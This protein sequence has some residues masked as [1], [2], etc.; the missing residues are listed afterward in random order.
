MDKF[1]KHKC[2]FEVRTLDFVIIVFFFLIW[3]L[4]QLGTSFLLI[5]TGKAAGDTCGGN[6]DF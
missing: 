6:L 1:H 4:P 3:M 5:E 2:W